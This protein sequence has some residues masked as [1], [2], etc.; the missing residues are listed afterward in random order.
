MHVAVWDGLTA[1]PLEGRFNRSPAKPGLGR[2][3]DGRW[4]C[5]VSFHQ[6]RTNGAAAPR[7][8]G[9]DL[10][11]VDRGPGSEFVGR[12]AS[13]MVRYDV[14]KQIALSESWQW[15]EGGTREH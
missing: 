2:L 3:T 5:G 1:V 4:E 10:T 6:H 9:P 8:W 15:H 13:G 14:V 11:P 7:C 12:Y